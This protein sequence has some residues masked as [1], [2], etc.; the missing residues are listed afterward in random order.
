MAV[1]LFGFLLFFIRPRVNTWCSE[2]IKLLIVLPDFTLPS[3]LFDCRCSRS[4]SS[5]SGRWKLQTAFKFSAELDFHF[6]KLIQKFFRLSFTVSGNWFL[7]CCGL[8]WYFQSSDSFDSQVR[9]YRTSHGLLA[10]SASSPL[11][12]VN[13]FDFPFHKVFYWFC[14]EKQQA[15]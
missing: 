1:K 8:F 10:S 7:M 6:T 2:L 12:G 13:L 14:L 5:G 15:I 11:L 9:Q 4:H 3:I